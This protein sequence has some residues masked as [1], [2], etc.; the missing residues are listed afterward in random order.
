[1]QLLTKINMGAKQFDQIAPVNSFKYFY[2][3]W[4]RL[5]LHLVKLCDTHIYIICI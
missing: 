2:D 5:D 1:M 4:L 3:S